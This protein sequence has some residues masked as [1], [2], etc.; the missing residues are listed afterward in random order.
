M[1]KNLLANISFKYSSYEIKVDSSSVVII[2][3]G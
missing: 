1:K 3:I 2:K